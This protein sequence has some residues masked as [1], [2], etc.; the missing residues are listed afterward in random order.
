MVV[1]SAPK[2]IKEV[3]EEAFNGAD[4]IS[5]FSLSKL[6]VCSRVAEV[7]SVGLSNIFSA[8]KDNRAEVL[9]RGN[10]DKIIRGFKEPKESSLIGH[11]I[12][13]YT[14]LSEFFSKETYKVGCVHKILVENWGRWAPKRS[15]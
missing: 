13:L 10:D 4:A 7:I 2:V 9:I 1:E 6:L 15:E 12:W 14:S 8:F 5:G 3:R 11:K